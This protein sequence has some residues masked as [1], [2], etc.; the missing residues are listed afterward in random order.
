MGYSLPTLFRDI[1]LRHITYSITHE[2]N[3][4]PVEG[5]GE[6]ITLPKMEGVRV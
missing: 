6:S 5:V 2:L 3:L 4:K 1:Y